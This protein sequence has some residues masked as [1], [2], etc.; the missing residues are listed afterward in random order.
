MSTL[1]DPA[2]NGVTFPESADEVDAL[3]AAARER[4]FVV[5]RVAIGGQKAQ[6]L[7]A[8][9]AALQFPDYFGRNWDALADCL[10]DLT[11]L[12]A[13]GYVLVL[14]TTA[15]WE[16]SAREDLEMLVEIC[17]EATASW[18]AAGVPFHVVVV[19]PPGDVLW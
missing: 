7:D 13:S 19:M 8:I 12:P 3:E 15:A 16:T 18:A 10:S 6:I 17:S 11:W 4:G 2:R 9:A 1:L 14:D 5:K